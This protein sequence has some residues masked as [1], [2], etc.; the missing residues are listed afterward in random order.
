MYEEF[1]YE[2]VPVI[3]AIAVVMFLDNLSGK[4]LIVNATLLA[5]SGSCAAYNPMAVGDKINAA[6]LAPTPA[7][8]PAIDVKF[9]TSLCLRCCL[10]AAIMNERNI[11]VGK[12]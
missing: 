7:A 12:Y 3:V 4:T 5:D 9:L 1:A 2:I 10:A 6:L 11:Q 8:A